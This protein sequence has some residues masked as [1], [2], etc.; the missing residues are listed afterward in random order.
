MD[1]LDR[2]Y[3]VENVTNF[4]PAFFLFIF[5]FLL[6]DMICI[7]LSIKIFMLN[8]IKTNVSAQYLQILPDTC[9]LHQGKITWHWPSLIMEHL[10]RLVISLI[11]SVNNG[12]IWLWLTKTSSHHH[13]TEPA[14]T[15]SSVFSDPTKCSY[16]HVFTHLA[17]LQLT[18]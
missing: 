13:L 14:E 12:N 10:Q 8:L 18:H 9:H 3:T 16:V 15:S 5:C 6:Q 7:H 17:A 2:S 11:I 1:N 4:P